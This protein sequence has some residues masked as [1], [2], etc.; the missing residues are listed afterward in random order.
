MTT[1]PTTDPWAARPGSYA[2]P[3]PL[4]SVTFDAAAVRVDDIPTLYL[5][6]G[7][8]RTRYAVRLPDPAGRMR[9]HRVY[10]TAYSNA[11]SLFVMHAGVPHWVDTD[12]TYAL[13]SARDAANGAAQ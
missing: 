9:W 6:A 11:S 1:E 7:T 10:A 8:V 13:E 5:D 4:P 2:H 12:A 3:E